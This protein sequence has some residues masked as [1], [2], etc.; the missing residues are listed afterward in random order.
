MITLSTLAHDEDESI[1]A[2]FLFFSPDSHGYDLIYSFFS[3]VSAAS[4][5]VSFNDET[6][7]RF[8]LQAFNS[9][10]FERVRDFAVAQNADRTDLNSKIARILGIEHVA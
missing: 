1:Y 4:T 3:F 9:I 7:I 6:H 10:G 8:F 2:V 5:T